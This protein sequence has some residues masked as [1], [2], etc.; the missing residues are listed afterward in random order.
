VK[1]ATADGYKLNEGS[2]SVVT[3]GDVWSLPDSDRRF[4]A[5]DRD[6][7][8]RRL[9]LSFALFKLLRRRFEHRE[10]PSE[11]EVRNSRELIFK[12]LYKNKPGDGGTVF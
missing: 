6:Q 3:V 5:V 7:R 10:P 9:C 8:L 1:Q 12:G 2:T 11:E 4:A